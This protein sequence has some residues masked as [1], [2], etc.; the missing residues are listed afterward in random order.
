M[1]KLLIF[2]FT[3]FAYVVYAQV[4]DEY[5]FGASESDNT[6][7]DNLYAPTDPIFNKDHYQVLKSSAYV[8]VKME[9]E[10]FCKDVTFIRNKDQSSPMNFN[11]DKYYKA[12]PLFITTDRMLEDRAFYKYSEELLKNYNET[13]DN[14]TIY[15]AGDENREA[16]MRG[17]EHSNHYY[18][19]TAKNA[20][21]YTLINI[22]SNVIPSS[23]VQIARQQ[24][25]IPDP[26]AASGYKN[27]NY[28]VVAY[29]TNKPDLSKPNDVSYYSSSGYF[30]GSGADAEVNMLGCYA[31]QYNYGNDIDY[32]KEYD[33]YWL[34]SYRFKGKNYSVRLKN[35]VGMMQKQNIIYTEDNTTDLQ[36]EW[37]NIIDT[38]LF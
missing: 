15:L 11:Q 14:R 34:V 4:D 12:G 26:S 3:L 32:S 36:F 1:K 10:Q 25:G 37:K 27:I 18:Y 7:N 38:N 8:A 30:A 19:D 5:G 28:E 21:D 9:N 33:F 2:I 17:A 23:E 29:F 31:V 16:S 6:T 13:I 20:R 22:L 35:R 24:Y